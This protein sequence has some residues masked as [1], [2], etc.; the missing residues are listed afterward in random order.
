MLLVKRK[1]TGSALFNHRLKEDGHGS[2]WAG[3]NRRIVEAR[4]EGRRE[5]WREGFMAG[6]QFIID[7]LSSRLTNNRS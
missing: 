1:P 3:Y 6:I 7:F 4:E 2:M 5:G